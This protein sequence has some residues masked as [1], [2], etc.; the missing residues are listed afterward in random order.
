MLTLKALG[1]DALSDYLCAYTSVFGR[2][3]PES[4]QN[5]VAIESCA[6]GVVVT[7]SFGQVSLGKDGLDLMI[8]D[9]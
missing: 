4:R 9:E 5:V 2:D 1:E 6:S 8:G 7:D 3:D